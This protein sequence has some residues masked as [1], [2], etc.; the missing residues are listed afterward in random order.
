MRV[1]LIYIILFSISVI[2]QPADSSVT[3]HTV[4]PGAEYS[5]SGIHKFFFGEQWRDVWTTPV[6]VPV[7]DLDTFA[8]GLI[9]YEQGGGFQTKSLRFKSGDGRIFKFRSLNKD[10]QKLLAAELQNSVVANI[11]KDQISSAHPFAAFVAAPLLNE[12]GILN[13]KPILGI[14]P[15]TEKLGEY[16]K[17]FGGLLGTLEEHPDISEKDS[18]GFGGA[19]KVKGTFKLLKDMDEDHSN[20]VAGEEFLKARLMDI[21]LGDWDRHTDQ[22]RWAGYKKAKKT[23]WYPIPRDR[24]QVFAKFE[25]IFPWIAENAVPQLEGFR[26][27]YPEIEDLTWSGRYLDRRF[28]VFVTKEKWDSVTQYIIN[29]LND[30]VIED[31]VAQL[32]RHIYEISGREIL[33]KLIAR[34]DK[35]AEASQEYY[36]LI[37]ESINIY[38]SGKDEYAEINRLNDN[39]VEVEIFRKRKKDNSGEGEPIFHRKFN[40]CETSEMKLELLDGDD[41]VKVSGDVNSSIL[42]RIIGGR[43]KDK[44]IDSSHVHGYFL[45]SIPF[46]PSAENKTVFYDEGKNSEIIEGP[47]TI[48]IKDKYPEPQNDTARYEPKLRDWGYD[49]KFKPLFNFSSDEG[50]LIG[51]GPVLYNFRFRTDPYLYRMHLLF[52]YTS[53]LKSYVIDFKGDFYR[54]IPGAKLGVQLR[55]SEI[56][57]INFY[58]KGN[59]SKMDQDLE[60]NDYYNSQRE[61]YIISSDVTVSPEKKLFVSTG[62]AVKYSEI[63]LDKNTLIE[64]LRPY[65]IDKETYAE[66]KADILYDNRDHALAPMTGWYINLRNAFVPELITNDNTFNKL[67]AEARYYIPANLLTPSVLALKIKGEKLWGTYPF[68]ESAFIGGSRSIRGFN[69]ERFAGDASLELNAELRSFLFRF[70][71]LVPCGLGV[72]LS[73]ES[74]R[75]FVRGESSDKWHTSIGGGIWL[76]LVNRDVLFSVSYAKSPQ[77]YGIY[78]QYGFTF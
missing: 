13:A 32:P 54:V 26:D 56:S 75:V 64:E 51:G 1:F 17:E 7:L 5:A 71:M 58:G 22:W 48:I 28:L 18:V 72:S 27:F 35:L 42:I 66:L 62:A 16:R 3:Y 4:I 65:G 57:I 63:K 38:G 59:E 78:L 45:S 2:A 34:R 39:E 76:F 31:A 20:I 69:R 12:V 46:I 68:Y 70:N 29:K 11:L 40:R 74:G 67:T 44:L 6:K 8:G 30:K 15:D 37:F 23:I 19:D 53:I 10:P 49:W 55:K 21:W 14:L 60:R 43:G 33:T 9:P 73:T 25:G 52:G 50:L 47:G 41:S 24:D 61:E 36:D 77:D